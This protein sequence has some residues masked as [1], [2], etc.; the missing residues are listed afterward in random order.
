M[1]LPTGTVMLHI[2]HYRATALPLNMTLHCI[3]PGAGFVIVRKRVELG[4]QVILMNRLL[5]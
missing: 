1:L 3:K 5:K 2:V 4:V